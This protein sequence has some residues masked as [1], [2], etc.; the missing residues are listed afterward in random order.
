METWSQWEQL[1]PG[2]SGAFSVFCI[3]GNKNLSCEK[4]LEILVAQHSAR[5][6]IHQ[7]SSLI[8][9]NI[10]EKKTNGFLRI[11]FMLF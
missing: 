9:R 8:P 4:K 6:S 5:A 11:L 1:M 2:W 3:H 10:K 7:S